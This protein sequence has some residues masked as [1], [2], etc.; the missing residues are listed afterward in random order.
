MSFLKNLLARLLPS[1]PTIQPGEDVVFLDVRSGPEFAA[2]HARGAIH[3]P[4]GQVAAR[5]GELEPHRDRRIL[6]Y[7]LSGHRAGHA[8]RALEAR[9]FTRVENAGGLGGLKRAGVDVERG[10]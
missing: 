10:A 7:C 5:A 4:V 3:I 1:P 2:G 8:V 9:G 6:V